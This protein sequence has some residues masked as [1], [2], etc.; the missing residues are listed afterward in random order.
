MTAVGVAQELQRNNI[1]IPEDISIMGFDNIPL[2]Q[3]ISPSLT[4]IDQCTYKIGATAAEVLISFLNGDRKED[5][6]LLF[7][8]SLV[9]RDSTKEISKA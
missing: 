3:M 9:I 5:I 8:P 7:E 6:T 2:S 4:T 1:R